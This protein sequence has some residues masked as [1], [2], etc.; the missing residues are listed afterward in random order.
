ML[1]SN[2]RRL[3]QAELEY[4]RGSIVEIWP[5]PAVIEL[6]EILNVNTR[7]IQKAYNRKA[8]KNYR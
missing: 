4:M 1:L 3:V 8:K 7:K 2:K 6:N 5:M